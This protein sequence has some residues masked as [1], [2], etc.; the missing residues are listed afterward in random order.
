MGARA[1][2]RTWRNVPPRAQ[3]SESPPPPTGVLAG[4]VPPT[5]H[6]ATIGSSRNFIGLLNEAFQKK[7]VEGTF[8]F[9]EVDRSGPPHKPVFTYTV[10]VSKLTDLT[11][12]R[13][14]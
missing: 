11:S 10:T 14:P 3:T 5:L 7:K 6:A 9:E 8:G 13:L 12:T 4:A 1:R 2:T